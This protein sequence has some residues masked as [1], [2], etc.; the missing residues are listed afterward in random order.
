MTVSELDLP[1][2]LLIEPRVFAD[3]RGFF[4]ETFHAARYAEHGIPAHFVQ[5][6]LSR[7]KR[8]VLRGMHFQREHPQ[9][10]LVWVTRGAVFD[11]VADVDLASPTFGRHVAVELSDENH[12][13]L[14]V[15]PGYAHGFCV[16]SDEADFAYAC[17]DVYRPGDEAGI[18]YD[19]PTLGIAWPVVELILSEKDAALPF[20]R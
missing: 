12:R 1:G 16:L 9:G 2:V 5:T 14:W 15:P 19:D 4:L 17:T 6:N 18:R 20:M 13:Q 3:E 10:K 11:V 7:S 8:G